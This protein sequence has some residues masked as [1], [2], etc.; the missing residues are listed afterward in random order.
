MFYKALK[1]KRLIVFGGLF[2]EANTMYDNG[3][4]DIYKKQDNIKYAYMVH[5][6]WNKSQYLETRLREL[7]EE[8][9]KKYNKMLIDEMEVDC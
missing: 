8:E 4:L 2:K 5:Y 7:T 1:G 6:E 9:L 3:E